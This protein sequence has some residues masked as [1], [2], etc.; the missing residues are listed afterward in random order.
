MAVSPTG[1]MLGGPMAVNPTGQMLGGQMALSATGQMVGGQMAVSPTGQMMGNQ[2]AV[3]PMGQMAGQMGVGS[4]EMS[5]CGMVPD[6]T[7]PGQGS[8]EMVSVGMVGDVSQMS[9]VN[10][11]SEVGMVE[12]NMVE[13]S[14]VATSMVTTNMVSSSMVETC[15]VESSMVD[16]SMVVQS[17]QAIDDSGYSMEIVGTVDLQVDQSCTM[18]IIGT[19]DPV[20]CEDPVFTVATVDMVGQECV[21]CVTKTNEIEELKEKI[22]SIKEDFE[23]ERDEIEERYVQQMKE[24]QTRCENEK[25]ELRTECK[26]DE[27]DYES[28]LKKE[29]ATAN[30]SQLKLSMIQAE[31]D[32]AEKSNK[33]QEGDVEELED[34]L[35]QVKSERDKLDELNRRLKMELQRAQQQGQVDKNL[36][37]QLKAKLAEGS[38]VERDIQVKLV[39]EKEKITE[40]SEKII[41]IENTV[42]TLEK[43]NRE[44]VIEIEVLSEKLKKEKVD[45]EKL[46][47]MFS[48]EESKDDAKQG[49]V[50]RELERKIKELNDDTEG[51]DKKWRTSKDQVM[52]LNTRIFQLNMEKTKFEKLSKGYK[53]DVDELKGKFSREKD[54]VARLE[55]DLAKLR[56]EQNDSNS[57]GDVEHIVSGLEE[58]IRRLTAD[59][60]NAEEKYKYERREKADFEDKF[61][62]AKSEV[63]DFQ[64]RCRRADIERDS[65]S[66]KCREISENYEQKM[67]VL[68]QQIT[69]L[70]MRP[71]APAPGIPQ[72]IPVPVPQV[73]TFVAYPTAPCYLDTMTELGISVEKYNEM[74]H[75]RDSIEQRYNALV[76]LL[77]KYEGEVQT[78]ER[79]NKEIRLGV[80]DLEFTSINI[81]KHETNVSASYTDVEYRRLLDEK[82]YFEGRYK[83][84]KAE[85]ENAEKKLRDLRHEKENLDEKLNDV[86][87]VITRYEQDA[88]LFRSENN[89]LRR[90][91]EELL[92]RGDFDNDKFN[93]KDDGKDSDKSMDKYKHDIDELHRENEEFKQLI[94]SLDSKDG[95]KG[96]KGTGR[97]QTRRAN[98]LEGEVNSLQIVIM[99]LENT[100][101]YQNKTAEDAKMQLDDEK[102][103]LREHVQKLE[104]KV[105]EFDLFEKFGFS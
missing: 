19:V 11:V 86:A 62:R 39:R 90:Q 97:D 54:E 79:E 32:N 66:R 46:R 48:E 61:H 8:N 73:P 47:F 95:G 27:D 28:K 89:Q 99:E 101:A 58:K 57:F 100:I 92:A 44:Y 65:I 52:E 5:V 75:Q 7:I 88:R 4:A 26:Q 13:S 14:T 16:S 63:A 49:N 59:C 9:N 80:T 25:Q 85:R 36:I 68:Q 29:R 78:L 43:H 41:I 71:S 105:K 72:T 31:M 21:P 12:T 93:K 15:V 60:D 10:M 56:R 40:Y 2:M 33:R 50:I 45:C 81:S 35:R 102:W 22:D 84:E 18:E 53:E 1:Q 98:A 74:K 51:L 38:T 83:K 30:E 17:Q 82:D 23:K 42:A 37:N 24:I 77:G 6:Q 91:I 104:D 67:R 76:D 70:R 55:E 103:R 96:D 3:S 69:E 34:K 87:K 20:P 94:D 64:E